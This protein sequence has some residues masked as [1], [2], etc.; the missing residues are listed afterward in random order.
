MVITA[1]IIACLYLYTKAPGHPYPRSPEMEALYKEYGPGEAKPRR[2][3]DLNEEIEKETNNEM[4][5]EHSKHA[6]KG[7]LDE[8][9]KRDKE[10]VKDE[11][12]SYGEDENDKGLGGIKSKEVYGEGIDDELLRTVASNRY[13]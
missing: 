11:D 13:E 4:K 5:E 2:R 7:I 6:D 3:P 12:N 1:S 9:E 8:T 10:Y